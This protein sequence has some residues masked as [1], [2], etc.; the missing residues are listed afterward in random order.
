M[1]QLVMDNNR[2]TCGLLIGSSDWYISP[3]L[4]RTVAGSISLG[5][6]GNLGRRTRQ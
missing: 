6:C 3:L 1:H 4:L 5:A 2:E